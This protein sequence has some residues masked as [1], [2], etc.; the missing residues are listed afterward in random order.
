MNKTLKIKNNNN[1]NSSRYQYQKYFNKIKIILSR[2]NY[3]FKNLKMIAM[4]IY[5]SQIKN[6]SWNNSKM[7]RSNKMI[8][9]L[10]KMKEISK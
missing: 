6:K 5:L 2:Q 1:F 7:S 8:Q 3:I 4:K 9:E 10:F